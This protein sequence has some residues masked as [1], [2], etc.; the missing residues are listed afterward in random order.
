MSLRILQEGDLSRARMSAASQASH[1]RCAYQLYQMGYYPA[2]ENWDNKFHKLRVTCKRKSVHIQAKTGYYAWQ[3]KPGTH[4]Q[5]AI[6]AIA[7]TSFDAAEIGL[8]ASAPSI[9]KTGA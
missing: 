3:E 2:E 4:A 6:A 1:E 7:A 8:R 5:E 9:R